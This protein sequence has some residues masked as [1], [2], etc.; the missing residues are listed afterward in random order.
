MPYVVVRHYKDS[1]RIA[2]ELAQRADE[3]EDVIRG[4]PGFV[5]YHFVKG[6]TG[7]FS[8]SVYNDRAGAEQSV[9]AAREY[10]QRTLPDLAGPPE[11]IQG[12]AVISFAAS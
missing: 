6:D 11:V 8:V 12:E 9:V 5:A 2:D 4:V 3:V 10:L 1:P 7:A